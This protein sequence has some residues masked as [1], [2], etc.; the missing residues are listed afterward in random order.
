MLPLSFIIEVKGCASIQTLGIN[1]FVI[2][3]RLAELGRFQKSLKSA[4][5]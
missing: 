3:Q 1:E 5:I 4:L 2:W